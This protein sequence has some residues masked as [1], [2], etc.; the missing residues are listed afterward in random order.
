MY[1]GVVVPFAGYSF[2]TVYVRD[3]GIYASDDSFVY[4]LEG[5][6][7]QPMLKTEGAGQVSVDQSGIWLE[8]QDA[9]PAYSRLVDEAGNT[10]RQEYFAPSCAID[11]PPL[12]VAGRFRV[13][14]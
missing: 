11:V 9:D 7:W 1:S 13:R 2:G 5:N 14:G 8:Y 10:V 4:R 3:G 12:S 6:S